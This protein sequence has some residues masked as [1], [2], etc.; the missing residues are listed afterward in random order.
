MEDRTLGAILEEVTAAEQEFGLES[1]QASKLREEARNHPS[2]A[3][4]RDL[5]PITGYI[6]GF[7]NGR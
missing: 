7:V 5:P 6:G 1:E 2:A 3:A 4:G